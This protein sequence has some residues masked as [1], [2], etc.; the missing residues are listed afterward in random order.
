MHLHA[1]DIVNGAFEFFGGLMNWFNVRVLLRDK[2][3]RGVSLVPTTV[4]TAWGVWNLYYYPSLDQ[5]ASFTG[6]LII[7]G[8][9]AFWVVL[10]IR[11]RK[12]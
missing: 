2:Q 10:A 5:W 12:N 4:F 9:N 7:V 1:A 8:A 11:Y 3:V 6:G